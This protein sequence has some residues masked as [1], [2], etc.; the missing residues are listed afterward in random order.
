MVG[1]PSRIALKQGQNRGHSQGWIQ[2]NTEKKLDFEK[3]KRKKKTVVQRRFF[4][5]T[6]FRYDSWRPPDVSKTM[7]E[8]VRAF[9]TIGN[10]IMRFYFFRPFL[11]LPFFPIRRLPSVILS[12]LLIFSAKVR[13][14]YLLFEVSLRTRKKSS[15]NQRN[16]CSL[17]NPNT[18]LLEAMPSARSNA[19]S[20]YAITAGTCG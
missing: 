11:D 7:S 18:L 5:F 14:V 20:V 10:L 3:K 6:L 2:E 13:F 19:P 9:S 17:A 16:S 4:F 1:K 8:D 12:C 15:M